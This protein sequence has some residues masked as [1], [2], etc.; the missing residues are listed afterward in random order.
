M[1]TPQTIAFYTLG[2]KLNFAE[3]SA[4][5]RELVAQGYQKRDFDQHP[6]VYLINTCSVTENADRECRTIVNRALEV[7]PDA[8][9]VVTGCYAQL[10]PDDI[11]AIPGVDLVLGSGAKFRAAEFLDGVF[12]KGTPRIHSCEINEVTGFRSSWSEGDRTRVFLKVQ[13][14]CDYP[15][16]YCTIPL[17]R[18]TS[19]SHSVSGVLEEI[20]QIEG[21]GAREIVLTGVNLGDFGMENGIRHSDFLQLARVIEELP[22]AM[23][24]RISSMEPNLLTDELIALVAHSEKFVPHFHLPLQSGSDHILKKMRR[25]YL[26]NLYRDRVEQVRKQIPDASIGVDVIVGF[27]GET[28]EDFLSTYHFLNELEVSYLHVFTYSEREHTPAASMGER[29][30]GPLRKERNRM[31]RIL[32]EKKYRAFCEKHLGTVRPILLE[33]DHKKGMMHGYTDNYIRVATPYQSERINQ[34][35]NCRLLAIG[36]NGDV[37]ISICDHDL[38]TEMQL[39]ALSS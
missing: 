11:A 18:G 27:P 2:C 22:T 7:N 38:V 13:D 17:A 5:G 35:V 12:Q 8:I 24:F 9:I 25:R 34:L 1:N 4:I 32:S 15:C 16:T 23:R 26:T 14:G 28:E 29:V 37:E 3:T 6:D 20:R 39:T 33:A 31:L 30:P 21:T 36:D 10:K 19:R